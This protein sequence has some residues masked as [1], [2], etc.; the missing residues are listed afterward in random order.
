[1]EILWWL[2]PAAAVAV[3]TMIGVAWLGREHRDEVDQEAAARRIGE[4]L[5]RTPVRDIRY[6][7]PRRTSYPETAVKVRRMVRVE[8]EDHA[9]EDEVAGAS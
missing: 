4:A 6:A 3:V 9:A 7:A 8:S 2:A 1:V 5:Q